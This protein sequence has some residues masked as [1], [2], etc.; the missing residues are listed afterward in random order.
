MVVPLLKSRSQILAAIAGG[1]AGVLLYAMPL[2]LGLIG[3]CALGTCVGMLADALLKLKTP[4]A[5]R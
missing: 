2:K 5:R 4:E 1:A 3:A